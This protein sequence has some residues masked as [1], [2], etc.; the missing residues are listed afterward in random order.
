MSIARMVSTFR[1]ILE[2]NS[3]N[4]DELWKERRRLYIL[5]SETLY[6]YARLSCTGTNLDTSHGEGPK[7]ANAQN[8]NAMVHDDTTCKGSSRDRTAIR[9]DDIRAWA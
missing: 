9:T 2:L 8:L 3:S 1:T 7:F 4:F 6:A 5:N